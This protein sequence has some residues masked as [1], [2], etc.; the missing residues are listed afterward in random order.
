LSVLDAGA[1]FAPGPQTDKA[2]ARA[3]DEPFPLPLLREDLRLLPGPPDRNG[4]PSWTV[5]DP[6]RNRYFRLGHAS[7]EMLRRWHVGVSDRL[8]AAI[9]AETVLSPTA[10]DVAGL[11]LFLRANGLLRRSDAESAE[12]FARIRKAG[13]PAWWKWLVQNYLFV[14]IPLVRPDRFLAHTQRAADAIASG[15]VHYTILLLGVLGLFLALRQWDHF[16][17]TFMAFANWQGAVWAAVVLSISKILHELAHAYTARRYGCRVPTMGVAL[18]VMYPVLYTDTSDS[19][20]LTSRMQRLRVGAAGIRLELA[21]ALI[22]TFLWSFMPEGPARSAVFL[23]ATATWISTLLINLNPFLRFDGYYLMSDWLDV[24]NLQPRAFALTRW[25]LRE[26][27]FGFGLDAPEPMERGLAR[28]LVLY[29]FLTW[30]YRFF[31]FLGIALIVY[32]FFFKTLGILLFVIEILWF[33]IMPIVKEVGA[34]AGMR[35]HFRLNLKLIVTLTL[36]TL[37]LWAFFHPWNSVI[38]APAVWEASQSAPLFSA[39]PAQLVEITAQDGTVVEA[40]ATIYRFHSPDLETSLVTTKQGVA[41]I[42][43]RLQ[44]ALDDR[45]EAGIVREIE[46]ELARRLARLDRINARMQRLQVQA[47]IT[48]RLRDVPPTLH[49]GQ[50]VGAQQHLGRLVA[51]P[52]RITAYV[53]QQDLARISEGGAATFYAEDP[54]VPALAGRVNEIDR[55]GAASLEGGYLAAPLGG[56]IEARADQSGVF[57][58]LGAVY[59]V[60]IDPAEGAMPGRVTRGTIHMDGPAESIALRLWRRTAAILIRESGF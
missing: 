13:K 60:R 5:F 20:R 23:I 44:Q 54:A 48:G 24:P 10:D 21:L 17:H 52:G 57:H 29:G 30:I 32:A 58:P 36:F 35:R 53:E 16:L 59:R 45:R 15:P 40:G 6:V 37:S 42:S 56:G 22:A 4:A 14:R 49:A 26:T 28:G 25:W 34:W 41:A 50:W 3:P 46:E 39:L 19:W 38:R 47:P 12:E 33:I 55:M 9:E 11:A 7:V 18:L 31:L 51:A 8:V 43:V 27:L 1:D 2:E